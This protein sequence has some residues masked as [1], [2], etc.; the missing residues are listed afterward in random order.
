VRGSIGTR[1]VRRI[2]LASTIASLT[3]VVS[4]HAIAI[5]TMPTKK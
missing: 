5:A 2:E 3:C 4:P 1:R